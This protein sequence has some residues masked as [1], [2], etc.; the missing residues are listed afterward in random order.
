[1]WID[2][3]L[4][5]AGFI[6]NNGKVTVSGNWLNTAI[7]QGLGEVGLTGTDQF[8]NNNRQSVNQLTIGG[9]GI[10]TISGSITVDRLLSLK[11]GIVM[12]SDNDTLSMLPNASVDGGSSSAYV[13]GAVIAMGT[14]YKFFPI[15]KNGKYHPLELINVSGTT[16]VIEVE[17]MENLYPISSTLP[18]TAFT[19]IFWTQ[20]VLHGTYEGSPVSVQYKVTGN[21]EPERLVM[22]EGISNAEPFVVRET[23]L[24]RRAELDIIETRHAITGSIIVLAALTVDPPREHYFSTTLS[25]NASNPDNRAIKIFGD[26][27]ATGDFRFQVFNRWGLIMFETTSADRMM[28]EGWDGRHNGNMLPSGIYPYSL[29]YINGAGKAVKRSGFITIVL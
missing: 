7:Y 26:A 25:P 10:K 18:A 12:V 29:S 3:S 2:G 8:I 19:D 11:E 17:V 4:D 22:M 5:N 15:G 13:D 23:S 9:G 6:L 21:V 27:V 20:H 16:P 28:T 14:G 24:S 1:M